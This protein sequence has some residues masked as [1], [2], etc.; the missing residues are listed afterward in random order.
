MAGH[1]AG[2]GV[3][4]KLDIDTPFLKQIGELLRYVLGLSDG[5]T[6]AGGKNDPLGIIKQHSNLFRST[7]FDLA[8]VEFLAGDGSHLLITDHRA[9]KQD[10]TQRAVHG[11]THDLAENDAGST[12][13]RAA[14]DEAVVHQDKSSGRRRETGVGV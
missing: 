5:K 4:G 9:A 12:D 2:N 13:E 1:A 10:G 7:A 14:D 11:L 8:F 3:D 6:V